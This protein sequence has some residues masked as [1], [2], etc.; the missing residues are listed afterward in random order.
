MLWRYRIS[1]SIDFVFYYFCT[2][3]VFVLNSNLFSFIQLSQ[4][5]SYLFKSVN[6]IFEAFCFVEVF[7]LYHSVF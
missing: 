4:L 6:S 3:K 7:F 1:Q 2:I 5:D